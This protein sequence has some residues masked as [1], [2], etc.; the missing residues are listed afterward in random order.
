MRL[1]VLLLLLVF[2]H[3]GAA[4]AQAHGGKVRCGIGKNPSGGTGAHQEARTRI[5][6]TI[7]EDDRE[8]PRS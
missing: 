5:I 3:A 2:A 6:C 4:R 8:D 7:L 1:A